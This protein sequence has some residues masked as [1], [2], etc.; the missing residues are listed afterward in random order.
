MAWPSLGEPTTELLAQVVGV[1]AFSAAL[2]I[3]AYRE[4]IL[5][6][7]GSGL[8][9][10]LNFLIGFFGDLTW[11]GLLLLF[12]LLSFVATK[13]KYTLKRR[14]NAAESHGGR[15]GGLNV[16]ANG[17][18]PLFVALIWWRGE[19]GY[20]S[21]TEATVMYVAAVSAAAADTLAS[22]LGVLDRKVHSILPPH[23]RVPPG[24]DGGVSMLGQISAFMAALLVSAMAMVVFSLTGQLA[25]SFRFF[26]MCTLLGW[27]GCQIDS[28]LGAT[29][30][31]WGWLGKGG[32]NFCSIGAAT[33]LAYWF[34]GVFQW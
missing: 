20:L 17:L 3:I 1:A 21:Q 27:T 24:V 30:E 16:L 10:L 19:S 11:V 9:F 5:D 18:V 25:F 4:D 14:L 26:I 33:L 15:R 7:M 34:L 12:V 23:P 29:L 2:A 13:F 6:K 31:K 32:V 8:A 28:V 22:E